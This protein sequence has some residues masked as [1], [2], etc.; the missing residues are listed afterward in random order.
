MPSAVPDPA[1]VTD[2]PG[3]ADPAAP[4]PFAPAFFHGTK[5]A[6]APGDHVAP[7]YASNFGA[8]AHAAGWVYCSATLDAAVWGA[9]LAG[10]DAPAR[11][12]VVEPT[13]PVED[14]PELTDQRYPGNPTRSYRSRAAL[15]VVG[16]VT[17]WRGHA[18]ASLRAMREMV[19]RQT[20]D[21]DQPPTGGG[22]GG[23]PSAR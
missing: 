9:E 11:I 8:R 17:G 18:P 3:A 15:R 20:R 21:E 22:H 23:A 14:D 5:A 16:E 1:D 4:R 6:L 13:G 19:A 2:R 7:G 12:Y 10:G